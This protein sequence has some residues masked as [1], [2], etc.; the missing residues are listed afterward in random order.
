MSATQKIIALMIGLSLGLSGCGGKSVT[1]Y[2]KPGLTAPYV[3]SLAVI[4]FDNFS[5]HPDADKKVIN[6][7]LT[8]LVRT[9]MFQIAD[10]GEVETAL[11]MLRIRSISELDSSK[12]KGLKERLNVQTIMVGSVDEYELRQDKNAAVPVVAVNARMLDIQTGEILWAA[13]QVHNGND[14]ETI[15]GFGRITSQS[16]LAQIVVSEMVESLVK[17]LKANAKAEMRKD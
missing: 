2:L 1:E 7:L 11:R 5:G 10:M 14:W 16:R 8:E 6:L 3:K 4:P 12:L 13:S 9:G 15:F 17:E